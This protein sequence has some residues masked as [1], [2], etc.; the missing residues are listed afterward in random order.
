MVEGYKK[1]KSPTILN[2]LTILW[3]FATLHIKGVRCITASE[4]IALQFHEG[5]VHHFACQIR[6]LAQHY[7]LFEQLP[8]E[9]QDGMGGR[10]LLK[11]ERVQAV[12]TLDSPSAS[13]ANI[14]L[15]CPSGH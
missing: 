10:S 7:Q 2:K 9:K 12:Y 8:E 4:E 13:T 15:Q 1:N 6:A 11:D 3:N 14:L 5:T